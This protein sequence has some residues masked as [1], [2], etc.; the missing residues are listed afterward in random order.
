MPSTTFPATILDQ[1]GTTTLVRANVTMWRDSRGQWAGMFSVPLDAPINKGGFYRIQADDGRSAE[2][3]VAKVVAS[4]GG[5]RISFEVSG[6][7]K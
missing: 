2:I 1:A 6:L 3:S 4:P 7:F 5:Q